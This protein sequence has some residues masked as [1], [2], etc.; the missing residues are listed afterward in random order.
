MM[1]TKVQIAACCCIEEID[2]NDTARDFCKDALKFN[3]FYNFFKFNNSYL[4]IANLATNECVIANE[5]N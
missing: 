4:F 1:I 2:E 5:N 3:I